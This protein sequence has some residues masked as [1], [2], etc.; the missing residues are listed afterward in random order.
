M[1]EY[2]DILGLSTVTK[3]A[4]VYRAILGEDFDNIDELIDEYNTQVYDMLVVYYNIR[5]SRYNSTE[6]MEVTTKEVEDA[7]NMLS[8][9]RILSD[10]LPYDNT[11]A[12]SVAERVIECL[13]AQLNAYGGTN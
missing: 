10:N 7:K 8:T 2:K 11:D 1:G 13:M 12:L 9:I 5:D 3:Y 6:Q 4:S